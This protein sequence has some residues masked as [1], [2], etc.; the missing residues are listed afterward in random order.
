MSDWHELKSSIQQGDEWRGSCNVPIGD[1]TV[2]IKHRKLLESERQDEI[3]PRLDMGAISQHNEHE[4]TDAEETIEELQP[5]DE[6]TEEE[7][8]RLAQAQQE[9]AE[10]KSDLIDS[11]GEETFQAVREAAIMGVVP[12]EE[13]VNEV[14]NESPTESAERFRPINDDDR[15]DVAIEDYGPD[16]YDGPVPQT[17]QQARKALKAEMEHWLSLSRRPLK[18]TIGQQVIAATQGEGK[19][20]GTSETDG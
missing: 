9:L 16:Q 10:Q 19:S 8:Q 17:R 11:I 14:I 20:H 7:E 1:G 13:D 18:F 3:L 15:T 5:K 4:K 2:E 12:D 6:L